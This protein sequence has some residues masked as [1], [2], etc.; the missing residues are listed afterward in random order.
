MEQTIQ[1]RYAE[2][3]DVPEIMKIMTTAS[4]LVE[5]AKWYSMDDES[6]VR[7]HIDQEGFVLKALIDKKTAGFLLVRYPKDA[8]DN[9]GEYLNLTKQESL[10]VAHMES[11]AVLP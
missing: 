1:I 2:Q 5:D 9:L 8:K 3:A 10:M 6:Y 7:R 4:R 11:A